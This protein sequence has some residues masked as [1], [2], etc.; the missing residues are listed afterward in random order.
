MIQSEN[1]LLILEEQLMVRLSRLGIFILLCSLVVSASAV[2][3]QWFGQSS[4]LIIAKDGTRIVT[5]PY[6]SGALG[7]KPITVSA[8]I[9]TV[10]HEHADHNYT[11]AI[12]GDP[13]ILRNPG[14][15]NAK[16]I[17]FLGIASYHDTVLG[18]IRGKNTIFRFAVDGITFCH[19]GDLGTTL[20][21]AQLKD[22]GKVNVLLIPVGGNFTIDWQD[23]YAVINQVK[24]ILVIPMH[25][26]TEVVTLPLAEVTEFSTEGGKK[27]YDQKPIEQLE[28][29]KDK[30]PKPTQITL[31]QHTR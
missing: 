30:L 22:I 4:F 17:E 16:G 21:T 9:V 12:G 2:T 5:D 8:D 15:Y 14:K 23:A 26:K 13:I 20:S 18:G 7:Y 10:S 1:T 3:V 28:I 6:E 29:T 11:R 25:Y 24:P 31:M 19:L 27:S